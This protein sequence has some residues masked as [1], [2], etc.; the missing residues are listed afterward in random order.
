MFEFDW[1]LINPGKLKGCKIV[2]FLLHAIKVL[3][4]HRAHLMAITLNRYSELGHCFVPV[5]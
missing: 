2:Q 1:L 3:D 4:T 5:N